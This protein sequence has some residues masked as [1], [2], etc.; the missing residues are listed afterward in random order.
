VRLTA[1]MDV[2]SLREV[3]P[4]P[5]TELLG[6]GT[7]NVVALPT[8]HMSVGER[9]NTTC[10]RRSVECQASRRVCFMHQQTFTPAT[11]LV[12][13]QEEY[14]GGDFVEGKIQSY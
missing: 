7:S 6:G 1:N 5:R 14:R 11:S 10:E 3:F 4:L 8:E 13:N 9:Y 2:V 12:F